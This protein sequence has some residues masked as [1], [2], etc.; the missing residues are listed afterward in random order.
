MSFKDINETLP[1]IVV[2]VQEI[3]DRY[4]GRKGIIQ[5]HSEKIAGYLKRNLRDPRFTFNKDYRTPQE[6]LEVH[7]RKEG[8]IIVASGLREGLDLRG[9]L[10]KIQIFCKI[11]Y[12]SLQDKVIKRKLELDERWY[13]WIT[14]VMFVQGLGRSVRSPTERAVTYILDSGFGFFYT[15]N[16]GFIPRY[17][18]EAIQ[19]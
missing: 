5:T 10:S 14:T 12:P 18:K 6:M 11:P 9:E 17:I 3:V 8:S 13:G 19:W 7:K 4:P 2:S 16:K 1:K 15:K